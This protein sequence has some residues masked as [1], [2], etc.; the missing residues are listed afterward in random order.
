MPGLGDLVTNFTSNT[1]GFDRGVKNSKTGI[2]SFEAVTKASMAAVK[3]SFIAA[4]GGIIAVAGAIYGLQGKINSLDAVA[5]QSA[6]T[7][8]SGK[9]LQQLEFAA[10]QSGVSAETL[11]ASIKKMT[12]FMGQA[13]NGSKAAESSLAALGLTAADLGRLAPEDQFR[14]IAEAISKL[15][16]AAQRATAAVSIFG[17]SGMDMTTLFGGGLKGINELME[18]AQSL[19]IGVNAEGLKKIEA[20]NDAIGQMKAAMSALVD[21][22][23]VALA[24]TFKD[25]ADSITQWIPP[26]TEFVAKFA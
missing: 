9:F 12:L 5:K 25:I 4:T 13:Q 10:D 15:P 6:K 8:L 19:G 20:A 16:T 24:P 17:K 1:S 11:T 14:T 22:V 23:T 7:G 3:A 21:Q 2:K 18:K 26:V